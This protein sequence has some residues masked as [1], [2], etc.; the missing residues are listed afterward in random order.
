[1]NPSGPKGNVPFTFQSI[2]IMT[3]IIKILKLVV[4]VVIIIIIRITIIILMMMMMIIIIIC[5]CTFYMIRDLYVKESIK[6]SIL[7][8]AIPYVSLH[9]L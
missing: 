9:I 3:I 5:I 6:I 8:L 4:V 7:I 2:I 1:M